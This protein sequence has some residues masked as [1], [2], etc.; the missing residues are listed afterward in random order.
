MA[1]PEISVIIPV[2]NGGS[3]FEECLA[4]LRASQG[5]S[6]EIVV[7]D[8]GS[9]DSSVEVAKRYSCHLIEL[10]CSMGPS[11]ARNRGA[12][13]AR[14]DILFF[15]DADIIVRK[16]ALQKISSIFQD[17]RVVAIT[18]VLS[19]GIRYKNFSSQFKNL[20]MRYSYLTMPD[21]VPLFYT[22]VAAI[23]KEL[24]LKS[25]GFDTG[26]RR[27]SVEDTDFGQRI[28]MM[29]YEVHLKRDLEVEHVKYYSLPG[30]LRTDFCRSADMFKMT[31]RRGLRRLLECRNKTSIP[32]SFMLGVVLYSLALFAILI[33][34]IFPSMVLTCFLLSVIFIF[35]IFLLNH[36]F[37]HWLKIQK[38]W[39]FSS[40]SFF[41][42]FLDIPVVIMGIISGAVDYISG[43][44]Y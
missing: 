23:R 2:K 33:G 24:F 19:D 37:L 38:G 34:F 30:L 1:N 29:G 10:P 36:S 40:R 13:V 20:W 5:A 41:F 42:M 17:K 9:T 35:T 39:W 21:I 12:K 18:G 28:E 15:I 43:N 14:G 6:Y 32:I 22:S 44:K 4:S 3:V 11:H 7:M 25:G 26:Y 31:I 8:D 27:P 16:N